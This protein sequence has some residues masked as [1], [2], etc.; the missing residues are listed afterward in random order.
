MDFKIIK[1]LYD[2]QFQ[3][4]IISWEAYKFDMDIY[5]N[6]LIYIKSKMKKS[7]K[8]KSSPRGHR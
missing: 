7:Y 4:C 2:S 1:Y 3:D 5:I 6:K 8:N